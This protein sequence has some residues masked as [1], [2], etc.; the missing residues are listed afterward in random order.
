M[1]TYCCCVDRRDTSVQMVPSFEVLT[2]EGG[3][4]AYGEEQAATF[5][6]A[7]ENPK[8]ALAPVQEPQEASVP[9]VGQQDLPDTFE[10]VLEKGSEAIGVNFDLCDGIT[11]YVSRLRDDSDSPAQ[12]YNQKAPAE[13]R[14][15]PGD[16]I[17]EVNGVSGSS[18]K[19]AEEAKRSPKLTLKVRRSVLATHT[20]DRQDKALGIDIL[21][22]RNSAV[23]CIGQVLDGMIKESGADVKHGD[24]IVAVNGQGAGSCQDLM[25]EMK[26][27]AKLEL[28]ISRCAEVLA[29]FDNGFRPKAATTV[30]TMG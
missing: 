28:T 18:M 12:R 10:A 8:P 26:K 24:R 2:S 23:L 22:A 17:L 25:E 29:A 16:Y 3:F 4:S 21:F 30:A 20:V 19:L 5:V 14:L 27:A 15:L 13:K 11:M 7:E 1:F 9:P 6:T